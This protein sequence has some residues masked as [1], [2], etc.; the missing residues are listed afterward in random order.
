MPYAQFQEEIN[1]YFDET[2]CSGLESMTACEKEAHLKLKEEIM[3]IARN[4]FGQ[5]EVV[6]QCNVLLK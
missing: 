4:L 1:N 2:F 5:A 6:H 3:Q